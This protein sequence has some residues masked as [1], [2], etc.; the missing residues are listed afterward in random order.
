MITEWAGRTIG[1][2]H[3]SPSTSPG[4]GSPPVSETESFV[5]AQA[6][7]SA[8]R[9]VKLASCPQ[10]ASRPVLQPCYVALPLAGKHS[11]VAPPTAPDHDP[12]AVHISIPQPIEE[13][14]QR[15]SMAAV[16]GPVG[17]VFWDLVVTGPAPQNKPGWVGSSK[18]ISRCS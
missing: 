9:D 4:P 7:V 10:E 1:L 17:L 3:S 8:T 16:N 12:P 13:S 2:A 15:V 18:G 11:S 14:E 5:A 6:P